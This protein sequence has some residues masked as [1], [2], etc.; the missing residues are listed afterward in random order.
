MRSVAVVSARVV[1]ALSM[2]ACA[3][4]TG[5]QAQERPR[6]RP[7]PTLG[8]PLALSDF[9][10]FFVGGRK[11]VSDYPGSPAVGF[12][13]PG[14]I[15]VDQMYVQYMIPAAPAGP[16]LILVHG[17]NH[18]GV[19]FETTPDGREGWATYFVRHGYP[20]YVVDQP[21]R[22]RSGFDPT[23]VNRAKSTG[24][25]AALPGI[26][27]YPMKYAFVNFRFGKA[28]PAPHP[29]LQFPLQA[30][31]DYAKEL[32]PSSETTLAGTVTVAPRD[33]AELLDRIGP[34]VLLGH[35]QAGAMVLGAARMRPGA[36]VAL[37]SIEG[38]CVPMPPEDVDRVFGK[39]PFLSVW[40]DNSEGA[41]GANGDTR[42][43]GCAASVKALRENN[44]K[45][46]F[47]MLSEHGMPGHSHMMMMDRGNL[48]IADFIMERL[49]KNGAPERFKA[50]SGGR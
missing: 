30:L 34:A 36:T 37:V 50:I 29:G 22:G 27:L 49:D 32:V 21:A 19:T 42:R 46:E 26:P 39:F 7:A 12:L 31:D 20:V 2:A 11:V 44:G 43:N 6:E 5:A 3:A 15:T 17:F 13:S 4:V 33:L 9:G 8:G 35:S 1:V 41:E 18:T 40:G 14:E 38:D 23:A 16:P 28:Y 47:A 25:A 10:S 45:A 24:D 48:A